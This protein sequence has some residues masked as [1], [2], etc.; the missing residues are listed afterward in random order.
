MT[1][2][3]KEAEA[4]RQGCAFM[5]IETWHMCIDG[6]KVTVGVY[7]EKMREQFP[8][9]KGTASILVKGP[10]SFAVA[11]SS[12]ATREACEHLAS[13]LLTAIGIEIEGGCDLHKKI[14]R[15]LGEKILNYAI[16]Y[17]EEDDEQH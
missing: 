14:C 1:K 6:W 5:S 2:S 12:E 11:I 10:N 13:E 17:G 16:R 7:D 15:E 3:E 9:F 8:N 4:K